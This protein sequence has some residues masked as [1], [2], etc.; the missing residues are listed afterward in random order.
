MTAKPFD[1]AILHFGIDKTGSTAIQDVCNQAR[2]ELASRCSLVYPPG[3]WHAQ[4]GSYFSSSPASYALNL[5]M[6]RTDETAI[7]AAD[8][9][10]LREQTEWIRAQPPARQL[11]F[12]YEGFIGLSQPELAAMRAYCEGFAH[13]VKVLV[14]V[15]PP[16]SYAVSAMSQRVKM[17]R[18][19]WAP[20]EERP[21]YRFKERFNNLVNAF[22]R[23]ALEVR[24]FTRQALTEG[25]VV[26]DFF[27]ALGLDLAQA[28]ALAQRQRSA[29]ESLSAHGL[30]FGM[31]L[32][33]H[34]AALGIRMSQADFNNHHG[35]Q[36]NRLTGEPIK[37]SAEQIE[38]VLTEFKPH[39]EVLRDEFG[40]VFDEVPERYLRQA[41]PQDEDATRFAREAALL[42]L[43]ATLGPLRL[44][45]AQG[46]M[47]WDTPPT[48]MRAGQVERLRVTLQQQSPQWWR[49]TP[50]M[51]LRLCYHWLHAD[52]RMAHFEGRRTPLPVQ[53][54][55]PG[56]RI[57]A[58]IEVLAPAEPGRYILQITGLQEGWCW[59]EQKGFTPLECP[60]DVTQN[61]ASNP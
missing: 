45:S 2:A 49:G 40:I 34:L 22:G 31:A 20:D 7:R 23:E 41:G 56:Q 30:A 27:H 50:Q 43:E 14:Y 24:L 51:P 47:V 18:P 1:T 44:E 17:G 28:R 39:A 26:I 61:T 3:S 15:R 36:L 58:D 12:S 59:F 8:E 55:H 21:I 13:R 29:N 6:G 10:Y 57:P 5:E 37:L 38:Y 42:Y 48:T 19:A 32:R 9:I 52:R 33:E 35:S 60:V 46:H 11:L 53:L 25:D 4:L 16:L 54:V